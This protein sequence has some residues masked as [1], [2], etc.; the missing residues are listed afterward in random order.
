MYLYFNSGVNI[1]IS[2]VMLNVNKEK[3]QSRKI[4]TFLP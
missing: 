2:R 1:L 3:E 4:L